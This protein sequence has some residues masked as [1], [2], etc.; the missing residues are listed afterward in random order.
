MDNVF[1][2]VFVKPV[3]N[4]I[5]LMILEKA[6]AQAYGNYSVLNMGHACDS[7]RDLT[8][9]PTEYIDLKDE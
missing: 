7:L 1:P 4:D 2:K 9:A 5:S 8:G 3:E 6:Y